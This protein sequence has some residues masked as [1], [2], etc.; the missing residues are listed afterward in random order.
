MGWLWH[1]VGKD[2]TIEQWD[3]EIFLAVARRQR[4]FCKIVMGAQEESLEKKQYRNDGDGAG[5][6]RPKKNRVRKYRD[7][8]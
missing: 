3:A 4:W 6:V 7:V 2:I 1:V 5:I 8:C